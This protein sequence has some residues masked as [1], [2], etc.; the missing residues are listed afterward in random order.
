MRK[1]FLLFLFGLVIAPA[2]YAASQTDDGLFAR[3]LRA[4]RRQ[5]ASARKNTPQGRWQTFLDRQTRPLSYV[6]LRQTREELIASRLAAKRNLEDIL[7]LTERERQLLRLQKSLDPLP[8]DLD[9]TARAELLRQAQRVRTRT[10]ERLLAQYRRL[11]NCLHVHPQLKAYAFNPDAE[12]L[13]SRA[14]FMA[15]RGTV[16]A[17]QTAEA[18]L[19]T[20]HFAN[21]LPA[22]QAE[23]M[24]EDSSFTLRFPPAR[25]G[26]LTLEFVFLER[27]HILSARLLG[28]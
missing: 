20:S 17:Y 11:Q 24:L 21:T 1:L 16:N 5:T 15:P 2:S 3:L 25:P 12:V 13:F 9:E 7:P 18:L 8:Q 26:G 22:R 28:R 23:A 14:R 27:E 19:C 6:Q 10:Q 4:L